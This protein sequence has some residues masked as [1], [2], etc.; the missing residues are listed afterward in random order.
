MLLFDLDANLSL[1]SS[2]GVFSETLSSVSQDPREQRVNQREETWNTVPM[3]KS[4]RTIDPAKIP[5]ISK[6][7]SLFSV[8]PAGRSSASAE[9]RR[10]RLSVNQ[11]GRAVRCRAAAGAISPKMLVDIPLACVNRRQ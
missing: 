2:T 4:S 5:K 9:R 6:V 11:S 8:P 3:T 7:R 10:L 1:V